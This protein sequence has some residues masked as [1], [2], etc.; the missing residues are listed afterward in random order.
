M[1]TIDDALQLMRDG[2][3]EDS[4]NELSKIIN[5]SKGFTDAYYFRA[6]ID[7]AH[8]KSNDAQTRKDLETVAK[9]KSRFKCSAY[10]LLTI[11]YNNETESDLVIEAG[12]KSLELLKSA[13]ANTIPLTL[14]V[15][16]SLALAY[17][18]KYDELSLKKAL[19]YINDCIEQ[20][21]DDKELDCYSLKIDILIALSNFDEADKF[22]NEIQTEFGSCYELYFL[23]QKFYYAIGLKYKEINL[24]KAKEAFNDALDNLDICDNYDE[25][26]IKLKYIRVDIYKEL[27]RFNDALDILNRMDPTN[28]SD[29]TL[30]EKC[31]LYEEEVDYKT[32]ES[33]CREYLKD[34]KSWKVSYTLSNLLLYN[35]KPIKDINEIISLAKEAYDA[36][37]DLGLL[38]HYIF[39][40]NRV[41]KYEENFNLLKDFFKG[42]V[43][44]G[45]GAYLLAI[46][47]NSIGIPFDEQLEYFE[48]SYKLGYLC[49]AEYLEEISTIVENPKKFKKRLLAHLDDDI[50]EMTCWTARRNGIR[51]LYGEDFYPIDYKKSKMFLEKALAEF[52]SDLACVNSSMGRYY[53]IAEKDYDK[54]FEYYQK[55]YDYYLEDDFAA[56]NCACGTL[57]HAYINGIG[58][59]INLEKA[60]R[61]ILIAVKKEGKYTSN[62]PVYLYYYFAIRGEDGFDLN[63]CLE[64]LNLTYP[65]YRYEITKLLMIRNILKIKNKDL[66]EIDKQIKICLKHSNKEVLTYYKENKDNKE[67]YPFY[68]LF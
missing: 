19:E 63:Y 27:N 18:H 9:S 39:A 25:N 68:K 67:L 15:K 1:M 29:D 10:Q 5:E 36:T 3:F 26:S 7:F 54:A 58:T 43:Y 64:L 41:A 60:K 61:I 12:T 50:D 52:P 57:A 53:E 17:F 6:L 65:F 16:Y 31:S 33:L 8:L 49:E 4:Y 55:A 45:K 20:T 66:K 51:Y 28:S 59:S 32:M 42:N 21:K 24:D 62:L 22:I 47:G 44:D 14:D 35:I 56:C 2:K 37:G 46:L 30:I 11:I 34:K 13:D 38:F 48:I 40:N 23:K